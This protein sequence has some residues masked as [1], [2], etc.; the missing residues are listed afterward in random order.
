[1]LVAITQPAWEAIATSAM[2]V[3]VLS[4]HWANIQ[5]LIRGTELS[6]GSSES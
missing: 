2:A 1:M 3:L 6:T 4:R 5:R